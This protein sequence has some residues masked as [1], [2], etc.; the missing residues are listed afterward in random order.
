MDSSSE[1]TGEGST[2]CMGMPDIEPREGSVLSGGAEGFGEDIVGGR[3]LPTDRVTWRGDVASVVKKVEV[4]AR[5]SRDVSHVQSTRSHW[6]AM[7]ECT[8]LYD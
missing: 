5:L 4:E 2:S 7:P 3:R 8:R 6:P 1:S